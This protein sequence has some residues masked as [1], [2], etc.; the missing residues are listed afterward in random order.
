MKSAKSIIPGVIIGLAVAAMFATGLFGGQERFLEDILYSEKPVR[1]DVVLVA[2]DNKSLSVLGQ[3]PWRRAYFGELIEKLGETPPKSL[4]MDVIFAETSRYGGEDD[5]VLSE[6]MKRAKFPIVVPIEADPLELKNGV[7]QTIS[8]LETRKEFDGPYVVRG[9]V[10]LIVDPD[11]VVRRVPSGVQSSLSGEYYKS[12]A[13]NVAGDKDKSLEIKRIPYSGPPGTVRSISF[14]DALQNSEARAS[15]KGAYVI[16]GSTATDLHDE[17]LTP[18]SRGTPMSGA[19]IQAQIALSALSGDKLGAISKA[20]AIIWILVSAIIPSVI[21]MMVK[22]TRNALI[23]SVVSGLVHLP[24]TII[25]FDNGIVGNLVHV[26]MA[27]FFS[28]GAAFAFRHYVMEK[29]KREMRGVFAKYVSRDVLEEILKDVSKVKLGGE[30]KEATVFFSDVRGFTTLSEKLTPMQLTSFLNR[31]L[32]RMTDIALEHGGV[33]D[34][35][36]GDAIMV[37][38]GAPLTNKRHV[39]DA[40]ETSEI[41]IDE[42][43]KFNEE[44][45]KRGDL[46]ID[47]GIGLNSGKVVAGNMGSDQRFD[48]T[49]MGDTVNLASRLEGQTK[50]YGAHI[51]ISEFTLAGADKSELDKRNVLTREL[52]RI[53]VKGKLQPVTIYEVV[54]N[55]RKDFVK[56][57]FE[58]FNAEREAYYAGDWKRCVEHAAKIL[59][60]GKDGPT[61]TLLKRAEEFIKN[62]PSEWLGV[63]DM[64]SK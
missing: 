15:L 25:L 9:A 10:N 58:E 34:K 12:F 53:R 55:S 56:S 17:Q 44:S 5:A 36:I 42:L 22:K 19:E 28:I 37:F 48:Y 61:E 4:G 20:Y 16:V 57:I 47:I 27:W 54:E 1:G 18:F 2:I 50:T 26:N 13:L 62:P 39:L 6:A 33:V 45:V 51:I 30:E 41:M 29:E 43:A 3:W 59:K 64:K 7:P 35:Y 31:Y 46:V 49:V 23:A 32:T 14:V 8:F 24:A 21:F 63:Y 40:I 38:W 60:K 11:G 52:D